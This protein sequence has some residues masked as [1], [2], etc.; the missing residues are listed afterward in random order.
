MGNYLPT[1]TNSNTDGE[2]SSTIGVE[3]PALSRDEPIHITRIPQRKRRHLGSNDCIIAEAEEEVEDVSPKRYL[4]N[5]E[6]IYP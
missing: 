5:D 1:T 4:T 2:R 3:E 6:N